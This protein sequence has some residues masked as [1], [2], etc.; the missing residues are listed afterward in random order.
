MKHYILDTDIYSLFLRRHSTVVDAVSRHVNDD[1]A[2]AIISIQEI[3][4]G[5]SEA[6]AKAKT[7]EELEHGYL[8]LTE[9]ITD[10]KSWTL[11]SYPAAA[12]VHYQTL[13]KQKLNVG[14]ND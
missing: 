13:K 11:A 7:P 3:W 4:G 5:W 6:I 8:K 14:A 10:L 2:N 12:I 1:L 9:T